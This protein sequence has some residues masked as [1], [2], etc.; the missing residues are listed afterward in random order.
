MTLPILYTFRRCPY[1]MRARMALAHAGVNYEVR[2]VVLRDKPP[3]MLALSPKGEVPVLQLG[4]AVIDESIDIMRWALP[5]DDEWL[6]LTPE[7]LAV[8]EDLIVRCESEFKPWL[9]RYKYADHHPEYDEAYSREHGERF[10]RELEARLQGN[11]FL[12]GAQ[13]SIADIA[14]MPFVRQFAHVDFKWFERC[15]YVK[16]RGWLEAL[17]VSDLFAAVM[18]KYP[19]WREGDEPTVFK[20]TVN[21]PQG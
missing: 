5:E 6:D 17:K 19:Q 1:A 12:A 15:D 16:L 10:L 2:E 9:D 8:V 7:Q 4:G 21:S 11:S 14:L 18:Q 3:S 20:S 13:L